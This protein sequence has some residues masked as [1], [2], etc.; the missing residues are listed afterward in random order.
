MMYLAEPRLPD[1]WFVLIVPRTVVCAPLAKAGADSAATTSEY[2]SV[3]ESAAV[4]SA[5][6]SC[7]R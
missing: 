3:A 1:A 6:A 2:V 7:A 5:S 4:V